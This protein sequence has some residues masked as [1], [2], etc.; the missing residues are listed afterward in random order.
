MAKSLLVIGTAAEVSSAR[1]IDPES[2]T[3]WTFLEWQQFR[4][5][6]LRTRAERV[7][8]VFAT[9]AHAALF[10]WLRAHPIPQM[11]L[12]IV[13]ASMDGDT[14]DTA[15][16]FLLWP[17]TR[18]ELRC[19]VERLARS[20]AP[21]REE[22]CRKLADELAL[23]QLVGNA[24]CFVEAIR[25]LALFAKNEMP[26]LIL[27]E[28][29]TGK[30]LCARAAHFLGARRNGPFVAVDCSALPDHLFEN[31]M[32]GHARGAYTDAREEQKG[33]VALSERGTLFLDEV[34]SLSLAAQGKLLRFLQEKTFKPL[35]AEKFLHAE[36][37]VLAATNRELAQCVAAGAFR[38]D[39][40]YRLNVLQ[41]RVPPLRDRP[42][43]VPLLA[44]HFLDIACA[45]MPHRKAFSPPALRKLAM[46]DWPGNVRELMNVVQRAAVIAEG[47]VVLPCHVAL[48]NEISEPEEETRAT[49]RTA[50]AKSLEMFERAYVQDM[51]AKHEGNVSRAARAAGKERRAFGRLVK[52]YNLGSRPTHS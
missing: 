9:G 47:N 27:G 20:V 17:A 29:G 48:P 10:R 6:M 41:V 8:V 43:D 36:V 46:H 7:V 25:L 30:E 14:I 13:D 4:P 18:A 37:T 12:A 16:D 3:R 21:D 52:K 31:E 5:E 42:G 49:F 22:L 45:R 44:R 23:A 33:L 39:L 24:P 50:R 11:L 26:I 32:F 15:D 34:D 28:T 19:R 40:Y 1:E 38:S 35:G 2:A 51:L